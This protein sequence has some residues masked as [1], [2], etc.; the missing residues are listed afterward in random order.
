MDGIKKDLN[1][2]SK[3]VQEDFPLHTLTSFKTGGPAR[4]LITPSDVEEAKKIIACCK[5]YNT[6]LL[7]IGMGTNMLISDNGFD[8]VVLSTQGLKEVLVEK[9]SVYSQ[10]GVLLSTLLNICIMESLSGLEFLAGIP[11]TA[12]GAIMSNAGLKEEWI[13]KK[14]VSVTVF[15]LS[16]LKEE[17]ILKEKIQFGYR[18]S[19]LEKY[20]ITGALFSL[21]KGKQEEIKHNIS[22]YMKQ[23]IKTQP[24]EYPSAGS[25]FKNPP[26][27]FAGKLIEDCGLKGY[28][29]GGACISEKHANFIINKGSA[30]SEDIYKLICTVKERVKKMY[31][32]ELET[33]IKIIGSFGG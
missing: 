21:N 5:Q 14:I 23:R 25:V 9:T 10:S 7:I 20:F 3:N 31:N 17:T 27:L 29:I 33:E 26:G 22:M 30:T 8:G 24:L 1:I 18:K 2:I 11:G 28:S 15:H 32:I 6:P 19:G 13:S 16:S 12:G 4:F